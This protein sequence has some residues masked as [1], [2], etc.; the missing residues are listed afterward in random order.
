MSIFDNVR[1]FQMA[2][3]AGFGILMVVA[4]V[5]INV[6]D[7]SGGDDGPVIGAVTVWGTLDA[8]AVRSVIREISD[9]HDAF[10][11]VNYEQFSPDNISQAL[12]DAIIE[13]RQPD[14]VLIPHTKLVENRRI[15]F[16]ISYEL[17]SERRLRSDYLDGFEVFARS[18]GLY[19]IPFVLD[20]LVLY[21]NRDMFASSGLVRPPQTWEDVTSTVVPDVVRRT[22]DRS[23]TQS[24]VAFGFYEN[25]RN[26][27]ASI[28]MLLLQ[29]G[30]KMVEER[31]GSYTVNINQSLP[32]GES[33][34]L[35]TTARFYTR[36]A[37]PADPLFSWTRNKRED[38]QEFLGE[39]LALYFGMGSEFSAIQRQN[40]NLNFDVAPVPQSADAT[41]SRTYADFYGLAIL[42]TSSNLSGA[43]QAAQMLSDPHKTVAVA[44]QLDMAPAHRVA[45]AGGANS[46]IGSIVYDAALFARG[47]LN[48]QITQTEQIFDQ[49]IRDI[50]A[51]R[52]NYS[53]AASDVQVRLRQIF[54]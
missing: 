14:M 10:R 13:N 49:M 5:I 45:I 28:S 52:K 11:G 20:P 17:F 27:F 23:V 9:E 42:Q 25:N 3:Y 47:W 6:A 39:T 30:S 54:D 34:P 50:H 8:E 18:N 7:M 19:A 43:F 38:R 51:G 24:P 21:W 32:G 40:P 36:F 35:S 31:N 44:R 2:L 15:L 1:P 41:I 12:I 33:S 37:D 4:I 53:G 22:L 26:A 29:A 46:V 16:P 48:P